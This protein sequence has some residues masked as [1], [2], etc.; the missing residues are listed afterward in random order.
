MRSFFFWFPPPPFCSNYSLLSLITNPQMKQEPSSRS[1]TKKKKK[2][3]KIGRDRKKPTNTLQ[4]NSHTAEKTNVK[5]RLK[6]FHGKEELLKTIC[7]CL[8]VNQS[9]SVQVTSG[10]STPMASVCVTRCSPLG[11]YWAAC[12]NKLI[13][14][15]LQLFNLDLGI[16]P[17]EIL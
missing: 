7:F 11:K 14:T 5:K 9:F 3:E 17:Q 4:V 1:E 8:S 13:V 10:A 6:I 12:P 16:Y 15:F 2:R